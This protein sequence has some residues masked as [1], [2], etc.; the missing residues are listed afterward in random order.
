MMKASLE[1]YLVPA[2][3][4]VQYICPTGT[5][6]LEEAALPRKSLDTEN[7]ELGHE[8]TLKISILQ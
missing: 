4:Y 2:E 8:H 7:N 1:T 3:K 5:Q 6:N